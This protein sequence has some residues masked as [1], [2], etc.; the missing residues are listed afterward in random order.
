[1]FNSSPQITAIPIS[2]GETCW[3]IDNALADPQR[4]IELAA[5]HREQF[6][7]LPGNAY[8]GLELRMPDGVSEALEQFFSQHI[9]HRLG[10]EKTLAYYSRLSLVTLQPSQLSP[11]QWLCHRDHNSLQPTQRIAACVLY[12]FD[13]EELGG[14]TFFTARRDETAIRELLAAATTLDPE[15][16]RARYDI[17]PGF[18]GQ[19]NDWFEKRLTVASR[20]NRLIFYNGAMFH[21]GDITAPEKLSDDPRHGR[22]TLNGFFVCTASHSSK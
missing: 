6:C 4:W 5:A 17:A 9:R 18:P 1:M 2:A 13:D 19:S 14:T 3:M 20:F 21:C 8:P 16:F 12:L 7:A 15:S 10:A 11:S 22:L